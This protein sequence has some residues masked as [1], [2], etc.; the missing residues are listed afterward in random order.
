MT[1]MMTRRVSMSLLGALAGL[2]LYG[3]TELAQTDLLP[4]RLLLAVFV[5]TGVFF[6]ALLIM[7]GP[8]RLMSA[9]LGAA[10]IAVLTTGLLMLASLRFANVD[11]MGQP[12]IILAG[13]VLAT[14]P[15]PFWIARALGRWRDYP[16]LFAESWSIVVRYAI[17]WTFAAVVWAV[18]YLSDALLGIVGVSAI[19]DL[20]ELG[21]MPFLI[22]GAIL[23][24]GLS[25]VQ[26]LQDY[27]SPYLLLRM[28]RL[29]LPVVVAVTLVF[30]VA[31]PLQGVSGLFDGLSVALVM[32]AMAGVGATLV[33]TAVDQDEAQATHSAVLIWSARGMALLVPV[34]AGGGAWAVWLRIAQHGW[35]P[36]RL[37]AAQVA[38]LGL[39]YGALYALAV[40]RGAGWMARIR[41]ANITMALALMVLAAVSLTPLLN[42]EAISARSHL[43]RY[44]SGALPPEQV[45][46]GAL[47]RW[48]LAGAEALASLTDRAK[49]PGNEAL[50]ARL[51]APYD[52]PAPSADLLAQVQAALPL[53][54]E[55]ATATRDLFLAE[56][57]VY[58]LQGLL[59]ACETVLP[60]GGKG[61]V[62]V[63]ADLLPDAPGEEAVLAQWQGY[64]FAQFEGLVQ[65][66]GRFDPVLRAASGTLPFGD[67]AAALIRTWQAAPP[68]VEPARVNRLVGSGIMVLE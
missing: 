19:G 9:A 46:P 50:A 55:T 5:L 12:H 7:A 56:F 45:D 57:D 13:L 49:T 16:L 15:M 17:G 44:V 32:L 34:L 24:L 39:G 40:A 48:G 33:T 6:G 58:G 36:D 28:L 54:P 21:A 42:A 53:Q 27:V 22:T 4:Q 38:A 68:A 65:G 25:V 59:Q 10:G 41:Q 18:I 60:G 30:L 62:M 31:L 67:E 52:S 23:G 1:A 64:G 37:F 2:A 35:T 66:R 3:L 8:L 63:V 26:E 47:G 51:A 14:V 29:I 43:A 61:C 20:L 11:D